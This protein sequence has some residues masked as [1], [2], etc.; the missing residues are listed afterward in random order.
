MLSIRASGPVP[1]RGVVNATPISSR[2]SSSQGSCIH[3]AAIRIIE[4]RAKLNFTPLGVL[5]GVVM[6]QMPSNQR[7]AAI[8]ST[9]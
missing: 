8:V 4:P 5:M 9:A 2:I 7:P 6:N 3:R 1:N